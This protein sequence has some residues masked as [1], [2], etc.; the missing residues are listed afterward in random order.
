MIS[1]ISRS[2]SNDHS[3]KQ[4]QTVEQ[5]KSLPS[6][7]VSAPSSKQQP[8]GSSSSSSSSSKKNTSVI[9]DRE[10]ED[11]EKLYMELKAKQ[12]IEKRRK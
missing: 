8:Q 6:T 2:H 5:R 11:I 4:N 12:S 7:I 10:A 9:V 1:K 3:S